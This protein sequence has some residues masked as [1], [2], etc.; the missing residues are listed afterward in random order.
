MSSFEVVSSNPFQNTNVATVGDSSSKSVMESA[1]ANKELAEAQAKIFLAKQ[2]PRNPVQ[3]YES[4]MNSCRRPGLAMTAIYRYPRGK[5][6]DGTLNY[7]TG[8]S[9]RLAEEI[10]RGWKNIE[11]G[12]SELERS[13][14]TAKLKA[15]AWDQESNI[16]KSLIFSVKLVR[17]TR[18]GSY[19]LTDE[20]DIYE[21]C[22]NQAAR[23]MRNC[24]LALIPGD[25]V[26]DA[27]NECYK[28]IN[29]KANVTPE[30]IRAMVD[31][32]KKLGVSREQIEK[33]LARKV[34]S[35]T[36]A[37]FIDMTMIY[38]SIRDRIGDIEQY[39]EADE[40]E[41]D[42]RKN[43]TK[44]EAASIADKISAAVAPKKSS[45]KKQEEPKTG[46]EA[47]SNNDQSEIEF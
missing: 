36:P 17:N 7:V 3:C 4:V 44:S 45:V 12:W 28:T 29:A 10:A 19:P 43:I 11:V 46:Q 33:K 5:N 2:F 42:E 8:P 23:R 31:E 24:I 40:K 15:Y 26:E 25:I 34:E 18:K 21:L 1:L 22:A 47:T 27:I 41:E 37:Q 32:F 13:A 38:T 6:E 9:I 35:I 39:F 14:T 30:R 16:S 20:R